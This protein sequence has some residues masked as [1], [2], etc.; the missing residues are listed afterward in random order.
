MATRTIPAKRKAL[1]PA[2]DE[3]QIPAVSDEGVA[4]PPDDGGVHTEPGVGG[5]DMEGKSLDMPSEPYGAQVCRRVHQ[6]HTILLEEYDEMMQHLEDDATRKLMEGLLAQLD[7][8]MTL[9]EDHFQGHERYKDLPP[10]EGADMEE[11]EEKKGLGESD[12]GVDQGIPS[13][14]ET[15][16]PP[17]SSDI[18]EETEKQLDADEDDSESEE[19]PTGEEALAGMEADHEDE[20]ERT[21]ALRH[22]YIKAL[23][24][25]VRTKDM[26]IEEGHE[27]GMEAI[28]EEEKDMDPLAA[29]DSAA[30]VTEPQGLNLMPHEVSNLAEAHAFLKDLNGLPELQDS[31]RQQAFHHSKNLSAI[32]EHHKSEFV[33]DRNYWQEEA[34]EPEHKALFDAV[35][36][37]LHIQKRFKE[38]KDS[39]DDDDKEEKKFLK[40]RWKKLGD[41]Y[42]EL[43]HQLSQVSVPKPSSNRPYMP[44][45]DDD[46]QHWKL[47]EALINKF[48]KALKAGPFPKLK[49]QDEQVDISDPSGPTKLGGKDPHQQFGGSSLVAGRKGMDP[50]MDQDE[51]AGVMHPHIKAIKDAADYLGEV[52]H[53]K[54][55]G[56]VH[57]E[58][59]LQHHKALEPVVKPEPMPEEEGGDVMAES[60]AA[61]PGEM[62]EKSLRR[63]LQ[64]Q[65]KAVA[66]L[67]IEMRKMFESFN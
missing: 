33:G 13:E 57:R 47:S 36:E 2:T 4:P 21:K 59:A 37:R 42:P 20:D 40:K 55:F 19:V 12:E 35:G 6:D 15:E 7:K 9:I 51:A 5:E 41:K 25:H 46:I 27:P 29:Q 26:G 63:V 61:E 66:Q 24:H 14:E 31:D 56:E 16:T 11:R 34:M 54:A 28:H 62:G 58:R 23:R 1:P 53:E 50:L 44:G 30:N 8:T 48:K 17:E 22:H 64:N 39:M 43:D 52:A 65:R 32:A 60:P 18:P 67:N 10:L 3:E 38:L 49:Q 45:T